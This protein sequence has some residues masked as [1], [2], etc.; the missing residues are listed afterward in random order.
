MRKKSELLSATVGTTEGCHNGNNARVTAPTTVQKVV[1][2]LGGSRNVVLPHFLCT[3]HL[4]SSAV[5]IFQACFDSVPVFNQIFAGDW[6]I[7][8]VR[9]VLACSRIF[10]VFQTLVFFLSVLYHHLD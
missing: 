6:L 4:F 2:A 8:V 10:V 1:L 5:V 3:L 9:D 7:S